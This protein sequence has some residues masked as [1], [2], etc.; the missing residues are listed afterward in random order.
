MVLE[1]RWILGD[2]A[3]A[4]QDNGPSGFWPY[5]VLDVGDSWLALQSLLLQGTSWN[6]KATAVTQG[7]L[8][9]MTFAWIWQVKYGVIFRATEPALVWA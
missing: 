7:V 3:R 8:G 9:N 1:P 5:R 4:W 6:Q 2:A